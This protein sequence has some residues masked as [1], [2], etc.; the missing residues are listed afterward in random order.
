MDLFILPTVSAQGDQTRTT[1]V[2]SKLISKLIEENISSLHFLCNI[3]KDLGE[4]QAKFKIK[5]CLSLLRFLSETNVRIHVKGDLDMFRRIGPAKYYAEFEK[6]RKSTE[7]N[8]GFDLFLYVNYSYHED[9]IQAMH[10]VVKN[11]KT[12]GMSLEQ[13][14]ELTTKFMDEPRNLQAMLVTGAKGFVGNLQGI[15]PIKSPNAKILFLEK[16]FSDLSEEDLDNFIVRIKNLD[17]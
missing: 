5:G 13:F 11:F 14:E 15:Y 7:H 6:L 3:P 1:V 17:K 9:R 2:L 16:D 8:Y 12:G 10:K 4:E